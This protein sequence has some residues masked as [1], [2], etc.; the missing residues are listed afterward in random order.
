MDAAVLVQVL[1][2]VNSRDLRY[3]NL[4]ETMAKKSVV[5]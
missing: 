4:V 1:D 3:A 2:E 5:S